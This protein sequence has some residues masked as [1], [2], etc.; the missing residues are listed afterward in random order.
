MIRQ[1][2]K[3]I[4]RKLEDSEYAVTM[5]C[6]MMLKRF[7]PEMAVKLFRA[8]EEASRMV[9]GKE[10]DGMMNKQAVSRE[11]VAIARELSGATQIMDVDKY[12]GWAKDDLYNAQL[13]IH[14]LR[15][16][17]DNATDA[18]LDP[19]ILQKLSR[20]TRAVDNFEKAYKSVEKAIKD[21]R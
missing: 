17:I 13:M 3:S 16:R 5:L 19:K 7:N 1:M 12:M 4:V 8:A 6:A 20:L 15:S 11:L 10:E 2:A 18:T 14:S 9:T 21:V